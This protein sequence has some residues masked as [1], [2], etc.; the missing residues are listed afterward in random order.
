[1]KLFLGVTG[2][3]T[4]MHYLFGGSVPVMGIYL[5]L[6]AIDITT[7]Y[8]KALK[9]QSWKSAVNLEGLFIKFIA[10]STIIAAA[11]LDKMAPIVNVTLPVNVALIWTVLLVLYEIGS[12][13]ENA[14]EVGLK[15]TFLQKW[16]D[17]FQEKAG[18]NDYGDGQSETENLMRKDKE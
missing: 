8:I 9:T 3:T 4:I 12:I 16:L 13:L 15:V 2:G 5:M 10:F 7:G 6:V 14:H 18:Q 11:A 17:V 1:M